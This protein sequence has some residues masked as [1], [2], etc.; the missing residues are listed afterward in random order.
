MTGSPRQEKQKI[1][2]FFGSCASALGLQMEGLENE[3]FQK[4]FPTGEDQPTSPPKNK[5]E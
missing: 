5:V 4:P 3:H 2:G 1:P